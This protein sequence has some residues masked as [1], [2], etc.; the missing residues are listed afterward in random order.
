[1]GW[2]AGMPHA[3]D[4][5]A[6]G[7]TDKDFARTAPRT[8]GSGGST[9]AAP[10]TITIGN[11]EVRV[12]SDQLAVI[13][14]I[15][16]RTIDEAFLAQS[17]RVRLD[18]VAGVPRPRSGGGS[19]TKPRIVVAKT[20]RTTEDQRSAIG[21]VGEVAARAW[22]QRHYS[23]VR[24]TSG[25]A[26]VVNGD[27]E[28]SDSLGYDFEVTWRDTT[29]LYEVKALSDPC[30]ERVEFEL[31]ASEVDAAR[32]H[33]RSNRYRILLITSALVPEERRVFDLPN[34]FSAQGR[35]R[36]RMVSRGVRYQC[37]PMG[38]GQRAD[39]GR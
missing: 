16:S 3:T 26:A 5:A 37:S 6:L 2:P 32:R 25:Y 14:D 7:L 36:F 1:V 10:R 31:G 11:A 20:K 39:L 23:D 18:T 34:P 15:A 8:Q 38:K 19:S 21:L 24:W 35:D 12:G 13:A 29:R 33:A 22:L 30:A 28:A 9:I 4:P 17:G 27:E